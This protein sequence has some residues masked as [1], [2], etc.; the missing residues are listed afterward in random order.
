MRADRRGRIARPTS[1]RGNP[2][3]RI[4]SG[5]A[6]EVGGGGGRGEGV[7]NRGGIARSRSVR[8]YARNPGILLNVV[9]ASVATRALRQRVAHSRPRR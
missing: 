1:Q 2:N 4:G 5:G 3:F 6:G 8:T 9:R 7:A